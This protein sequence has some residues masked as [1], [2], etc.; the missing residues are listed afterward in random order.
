MRNRFSYLIWILLLTVPSG[1]R[2]QKQERQPDLQ[3]YLQRLIQSNGSPLPKD[4]DLRVAHGIASTPADDIALALPTLMAA[5]RNPNDMVKR[6]AVTPLYAISQ[7]PDSAKLLSP[8]IES[9]AG[10]FAQED[11]I[12]QGI[13]PIILLN[14]KPQLPPEVVPPILSFVKRT[15]RDLRAQSSA[16]SELLRKEPQNPAVI[17]ATEE[18]L[19]RPLDKETREGALNGIANSGTTDA[20]LVQV[21]I[22]ALDSPDEGVR[23]TAAQAFWR[24]PKE[25]VVQA[26]PALLKVAARSDESPEVKAAA[27]RALEESSR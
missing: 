17:A 8:Y 25:A 23:L 7:R 15:D 1:C 21:L 26:R 11:P 3:T 13:P 10:L 2:A 12:L 24:M 4:D 16:I 19:S 20:R 18:F 5:L 6:Y 14:L 22:A 9:I 27:R